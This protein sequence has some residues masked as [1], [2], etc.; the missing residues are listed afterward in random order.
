MPVHL[1]APAA[2]GGAS[3]R[4]LATGLR[5]LDL[6]YGGGITVGSSALVAGS[7]G[8]GKSTGLLQAAGEVGRRKLA[9]YAS[10]EESVDALRDRCERLGIA[11]RKHLV[12]MHCRR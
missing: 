5:G 12:P 9:I 3:S 7:A 10:V 1:L 2:R 6:V 11:D 8:A 4:R